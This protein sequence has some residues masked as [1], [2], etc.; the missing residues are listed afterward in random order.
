LNAVLMQVG[1]HHEIV[2]PY[3][4]R[5][6]GEMVASCKDQPLLKSAYAA[7]RSCAKYLRKNHWDVRKG[8]RGCGVCVPCLFRRAA[9][10]P[11]DWDT[12]IYGVDLHQFT[13]LENIPSDLLALCAFC[14]RDHSASE[15]AR[16]LLA[17][18]SFG[19]KELLNYAD[20]VV[21]MRAEVR[22]WIKIRTPGFVQNLAGL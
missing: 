17:N 20:V 5:T 3:A 8:V 15:I 9:L 21:R 4:R 11:A 7:T 13:V 14:R 18:G 19:T 2:N 10:S 16:G 12:E 22:E 1:F 6:K